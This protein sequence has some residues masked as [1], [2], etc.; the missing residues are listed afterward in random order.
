MSVKPE[1]A[2]AAR[3]WRNKLDSNFVSDNGEPLHGM[4]A[5]MIPKDVLTKEQLDTFEESLAQ[6]V[7]RKMD[8]RPPE[9]GITAGSV[10]YDPCEL[11]RD[12]YLAS[13]GK[14]PGLE[15]FPWKT[16]VRTMPGIIQ[17]KCGYGQPWENIN[18]AEFMV[19]PISV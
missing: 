4:V 18:A 8:T 14:L 10:D 1:A 12:A 17:V 5:A 13:V 15:T 7:S 11:L 19:Q 9:H 6:L 2:A 16:C 3:W